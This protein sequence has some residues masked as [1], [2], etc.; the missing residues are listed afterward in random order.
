MNLRCT[1][2][3]DGIQNVLWNI[4]SSRSYTISCFVY[5]DLF[6]KLV[7]YFC[8]TFICSND[9][10]GL[11][12][13]SYTFKLDT[14]IRPCFLWP[15]ISTFLEFSV[16]ICV[17]AFFL[18]FKGRYKIPESLNFFYQKGRSNTLLLFLHYMIYLLKSNTSWT[19]MQVS[20]LVRGNL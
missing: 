11:K 16:T 1:T 15:Q 14:Q 4:P 20:G 10:F 7:K 17:A 13:H 8:Y 5:K 6:K 18:V 19:W 3:S 9:F 12:I 2:K